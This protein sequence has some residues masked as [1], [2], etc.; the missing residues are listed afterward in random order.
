M[1]GDQTTAKYNI[2]CGNLFR[3]TKESDIYSIRYLFAVMAVAA[4]VL[5]SWLGVAASLVT[6]HSPTG[7]LV[8][9]SFTL[10]RHPL[11][12]SSSYHILHNARVIPAVHRKQASCKPLARPGSFRA[13]SFVANERH[14]DTFVAQCGLPGGGSLFPPPFFFSNH[15]KHN[16]INRSPS[17]STPVFD[18]S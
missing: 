6:G 9:F 14:G 11:L 17:V 10:L 13:A 15:N 4:S 7:P 1:N 12:S 3:Y 8:G 18:M 2:A 16:F 5:L